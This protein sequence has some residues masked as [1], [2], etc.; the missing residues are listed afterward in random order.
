MM[1]GFSEV[2]AYPARLI[3]LAMNVVMT[4]ARFVITLHAD[5]RACDKKGEE[6]GNALFNDSLNTFYL[7]LYDVKKEGRK[8]FI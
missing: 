4:A 2:R 5:A 8:C 6:E 7:Q 3:T 1:A